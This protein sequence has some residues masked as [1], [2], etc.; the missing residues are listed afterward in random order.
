MSIGQYALAVLFFIIGVLCAVVIVRKFLPVSCKVMLFVVFVGSTVLLGRIIN[1]P[2]IS[3]IEKYVVSAVDGCFICLLGAVEGV[4]DD[5]W[6]TAKKLSQ[7]LKN[8]LERN[9]QL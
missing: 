6:A 2:N 3:L 7:M 5:Y 8:M 4:I 9:T 1:N